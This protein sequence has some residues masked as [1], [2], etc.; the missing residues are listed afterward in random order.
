MDKITRSFL[1]FPHKFSQKFTNSMLMFCVTMEIE[2][3]KTKGRLFPKAALV[4]NW[5]E[6]KR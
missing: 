2:E 3:K 1:F 6:R 5:A 4:N